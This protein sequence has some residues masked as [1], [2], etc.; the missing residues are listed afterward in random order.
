MPSFVASDALVVTGL[1]LPSDAQ[2]I[3]QISDKGGAK[4]GAL[5]SDQD[6]EGV[7]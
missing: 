6:L 7:I 5:T 3:I 4:C 2:A 1:A